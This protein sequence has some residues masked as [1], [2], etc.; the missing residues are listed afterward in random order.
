M[1]RR[2]MRAGAVAAAGLWVVAGCLP[3]AGPF[4]RHELRKTAEAAYLQDIAPAEEDP[5]KEARGFFKNNRNAGS[6][7][8][9]AR[10]IEKSLGAIE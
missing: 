6:L 9:E 7:S 10:D 3:H 1:D 4:R 8:S 2:R 5:A